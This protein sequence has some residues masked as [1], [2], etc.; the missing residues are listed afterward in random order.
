MPSRNCPRLRCP[1]IPSRVTTRTT[2]RRRWTWLPLPSTLSSELCLLVPPHCDMYNKVS[3]PLH[4]SPYSRTFL[5][6][7]PTTLNPLLQSFSIYPLSVH[8]SV[9]CLSALIF[10]RL[11]VS[12][13]FLPILR[14]LHSFS[15]RMPY[16]RISSTSNTSWPSSAS[17]LHKRQESYTHFVICT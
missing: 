10:D 16:P 5:V 15:G 11:L 14:S 8:G 9:T 13:V 6:S 7:S 1:S 4:M 2:S 12:P 17:D 3:G